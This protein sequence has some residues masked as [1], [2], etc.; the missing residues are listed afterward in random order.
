[1]RRTDGSIIRAFD[2]QVGG[3]MV[4]ALRQTLHGALMSEV[5]DVALVLG[6]EAVKVVAGANDVSLVLTDGRT[7]TGDVVVGADGVGSVVR[8]QLHP[9]EPPPVRSRFCALRGVAYGVG[10]E[11]GDLAAVGYFGDGVEAATARASADAVYWYLSMLTSDVSGPERAPQAI[12]EDRTA[13]FD[14]RFRSVA[15]ATKPDDMRFDQLFERRAL[16]EW[17]TGRVTLLGDAAHPML[18]HTGQG[19]AQAL[20]DAVALGL[21]LA[22]ADVESALRRYERVRSRRTRRVV[23][24]GPRIARIT[25]TRSPLVSLL[26]TAAIR[27]L[28]ESVLVTAA[29]GRGRDPHRQLRSVADLR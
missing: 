5:G 7:V 8:R 6:S 9:N 29:S 12:L 13:A 4:V 10:D 17:S 22:P 24:L 18:P 23:T 25:T 14:P 1:V 28:P 19:A 21:A 11:L 16:G 20:E 15:S 27:W 26:R 3:P 2:A